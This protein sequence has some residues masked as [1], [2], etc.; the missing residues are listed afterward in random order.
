MKI[1]YDTLEISWIAEYGSFHRYL[2]GVKAKF[3]CAGVK[4]NSLCAPQLKAQECATFVAG[5]LRP[6]IIANGEK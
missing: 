2:S 4:G 5:Q 6:F 1:L 3:R